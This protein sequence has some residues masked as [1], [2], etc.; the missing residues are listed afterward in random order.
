MFLDR[1]FPKMARVRT[2]D[3]A[4]ALFAIEGTTKTVA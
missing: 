4:I 3:E 2:T 1:V